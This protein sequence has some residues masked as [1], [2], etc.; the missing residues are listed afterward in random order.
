MKRI[1]P[2][3]FAALMILAL[4]AGCQVTGVP[5]ASAV[6]SPQNAA[7]LVSARQAQV[8]AFFD[9]VWST[10]SATLLLLQGGEAA[11]IDAKTLNVTDRLSFESPVMLVSAAP[12]GKTLVYS[13]D[14]ST[15]QV[16]DISS[17]QPAQVIDPGIPINNIDFSEDGHWLLVTSMDV[18]E[19][20][21]WDT[22]SRSEVK[23]L[24]GFDTAA[25]VYNV[26]FGG[27]NAHILWIS[28]GTVQLMAID[29][30]QLGMQANHEDFV[31]DAQLSSDGK[32]LAT[33]AYGIVR[34][35]FTPV[36][37]IWDAASGETL[38]LLTDSE[39]FTRL[40]FSPDSRLIAAANGGRVTIWDT[41]NP[42]L[43]AEYQ[44]GADFIDTLAFS[45]DGS[46]LAIALSDGTLA[47][48]QVK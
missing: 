35:E 30:G 13:L 25:P 19:A 4:A 40:S 1:L 39:S 31:M 17:T 11:R 16:K 42:Q 3:F 6:I 26:M 38:G 29:S 21:L 5:P 28:R 9:L 20:R 46:M 23:T 22:A 10:D 15:L 43:L 41:A 48:W 33:S 7:Q 37:A 12:D 2:R 14:G 47:I 24:S 44:S 27:D 18:I 32:L 36:L 8:G 34:E 45:P